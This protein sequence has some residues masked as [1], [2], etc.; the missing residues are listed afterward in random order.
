MTNRW[1]TLGSSIGD[2]SRPFSPCIRY[3][4]DTVGHELVVTNDKALFGVFG[5]SE[6]EVGDI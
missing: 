6:L 4:P 2:S 3:Q 1:V 5:P